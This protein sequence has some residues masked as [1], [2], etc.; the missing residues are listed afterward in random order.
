LSCYKRD[1]RTS[2]TDQIVSKCR[3]WSSLRSRF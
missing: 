2:R 1:G 3:V